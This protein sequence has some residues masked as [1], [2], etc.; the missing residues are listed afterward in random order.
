M[1]VTVCHIHF[2]FFFSFALIFIIIFFIIVSTFSFSFSF[3]LHFHVKFQARG[4][5]HI[6]SLICISNLDGIDD[7]SVDGE[8]ATEQ[9]KVK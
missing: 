5:P 9:N 7:S 3:S 8:L 4:T 2:P 1:Y 6:H